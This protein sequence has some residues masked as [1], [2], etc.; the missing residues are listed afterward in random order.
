KRWVDGVGTRDK[1][2]TAFFQKDLDQSTPQWVK[3]GLMRHK[4]HANE[5]PLANDAATL[6]WFAQI[7]AL[8]LHVPQWQF[9]KNGQSKR[10]DR[11]CLD[12]DPGRVA[13]LVEF[14]DV[15]LL[16]RTVL[17]GM[18]L[19][20]VPVTSGSSGIHVYAALDGK[21]SASAVENIAYELA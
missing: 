18:G 15:A 14:A 8:E 5:Y 9:G 1:P 3:R 20:P 16:A 13:G 12:M 4:D 19:R 7:A 11:L 2:R 17:D 10:P 6:A 21:R